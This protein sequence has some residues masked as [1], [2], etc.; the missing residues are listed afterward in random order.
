MVILAEVPL[1]EKEKVLVGLKMMSLR[2]LS[3][4]FGHELEV[5]V[6]LL[7]LKDAEEKV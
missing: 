7:G 2:M 5:E 3:W 1:P 4:L 6:M